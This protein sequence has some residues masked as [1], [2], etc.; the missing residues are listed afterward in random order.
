MSLDK[1]WFTKDRT[2]PDPAAM[3][4]LRSETMKHGT[5]VLPTDHAKEFISSTYIIGI[6]EGP[7]NRGHLKTPYDC[8]S[9]GRR[10]GSRMQE[11][12]SSN[13]TLGV[14]GVSPLQASGGISTLQLPASGLRP[15]EQPAGHSHP[16]Q[17]QLR[18]KQTTKASARRL[19]ILTATL[20]VMFAA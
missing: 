18:V 16:E 4:I 3:G 15:P 19:R 20:D 10:I 14:S 8:S 2:T 5:L 12:W 17:K 7:L 11:V 9:V 6:F 1:C 13:P